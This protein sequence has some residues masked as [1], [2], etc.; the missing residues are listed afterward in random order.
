MKRQTRQI[1]A[2]LAVIGTGIAGCAAS[3]FA[4]DLGLT[5]AQIGHSGAM[6]YTT[7]YFDL[8]GVLDGQGLEDPW[9]GLDRLRNT[10]SRHPY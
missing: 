8:L 9:S 4:R 2:D 10:E 1:T 3:I 5:V 6:A 7:G